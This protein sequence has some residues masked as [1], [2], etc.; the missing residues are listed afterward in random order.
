MCIQHFEKDLLP[1]PGSPLATTVANSS[2]RLDLVDLQPL[3]HET[4]RVG[5]AT[6]D[7]NDICLFIYLFSHGT[8]ARAPFYV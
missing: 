1:H 8:S 6:V 3:D 4:L 2:S 5:L 7:L